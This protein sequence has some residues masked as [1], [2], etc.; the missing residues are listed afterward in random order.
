M[1]QTT[2]QIIND[3]EDNAP[4]LLERIRLGKQVQTFSFKQEVELPSYEEFL[5]WLEQLYGDALIGQEFLATCQTLGLQPP[6]KGKI[7]EW[8]LS[9]MRQQAQLEQS[10]LSGADST[11]ESHSTENNLLDVNSQPFLEYLLTL[12]A[13]PTEEEELLMARRFGVEQ[14][15]IKKLISRMRF[16]KND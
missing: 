16:N 7:E 9:K 8:L 14:A 10:N 13:M 4:N 5:T 15:L 11:A 3:E 6:Q 2:I 12:D 1:G